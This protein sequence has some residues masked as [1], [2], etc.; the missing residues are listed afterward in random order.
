MIENLSKINPARISRKSLFSNI[1]SLSNLSIN[2]EYHIVYFLQRR[3][4]SQSNS[5][6]ND[7]FTF[8]FLRDALLATIVFMAR[9]IIRVCLVDAVSLVLFSQRT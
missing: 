7:S 2:Y 9:R 4:V 6:R 8:F 3:R 1:I 5:K